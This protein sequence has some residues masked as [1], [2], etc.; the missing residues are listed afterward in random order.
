MFPSITINYYNN[1]GIVY[2]VNLLWLRLT[3]SFAL[4]A[5]AFF[6]M[7][8][9]V[10]NCSTTSMGIILFSG[11]LSHMGGTICYLWAS[12]F[13]PSVAPTIAASTSSELAEHY[14]RM[15]QF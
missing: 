3:I 12:R 1:R 9:S 13:I 15:K 10:A 2:G 4:S 7:R 6:T 11:T 14:L 8:K 5:F